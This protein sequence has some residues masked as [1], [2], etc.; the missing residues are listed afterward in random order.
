MISSRC[1]NYSVTGYVNA[2]VRASKFPVNG[3]SLRRLPSWPD[4]I[5]QM[6]SMALAD[7]FGQLF[8]KH[9]SSA[10]AESASMRSERLKDQLIFTDASHPILTHLSRTVVQYHSYRA[11]YTCQ[12]RQKSPRDRFSTIN[13]RRSRWTLMTPNL[14][15]DV[16]RTTKR[17]S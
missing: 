14:P 6:W 5:H 17:N 9:S 13:C 12:M 11:P 3:N 16:T 1:P 10:S 8:R 15:F 4:P 7:P 2:S